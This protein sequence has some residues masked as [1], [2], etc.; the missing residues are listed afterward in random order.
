[1][2]KKKGQSAY[3]KGDEIKTSSSKLNTQTYRTLANLFAGGDC[4]ESEFGEDEWIPLFDEV[5]FYNILLRILLVQKERLLSQHK[6]IHQKI[7]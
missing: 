4:G 6:V 1:M 2:V 7:H 3:L 5:F